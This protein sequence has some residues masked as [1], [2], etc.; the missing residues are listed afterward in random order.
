MN[1]E[2]LKIGAGYVLI[3]LLWGSTWM[4]IRIGLDY[5]TPFISCGI[6]FLIGGDIYILNYVL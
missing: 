1:N 2:R 5:L 3:C 6:R 4:A